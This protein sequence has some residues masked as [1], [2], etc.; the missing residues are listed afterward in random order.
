M[1]EK[2]QGTNQ[3]SM[4]EKQQVSSKESMQE[5][6]KELGKKVCMKS[7]KEVHNKEYARKLQRYYSTLACMDFTCCQQ[8]PP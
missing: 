8:L 6:S 4:Q 5:N 7:S 1:Q 3:E 2:D